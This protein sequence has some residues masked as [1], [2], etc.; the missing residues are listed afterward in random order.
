MIRPVLD[1][2]I[3]IQSEGAGMS[4]GIVIANPD[5][6]SRGE[7]VAVGPGRTAKDGRVLPLP[8]TVGQTVE[9]W[10]DGGQRLTVA[11]QEYVILGEP[12]V[13]GVYE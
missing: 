11:G 8:F 7:V 1:R 2:I 10:P 3:V 6:P 4:G 12:E 13:L 9:W 5:R